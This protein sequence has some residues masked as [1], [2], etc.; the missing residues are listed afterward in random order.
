MYTPVQKHRVMFLVI[1]LMVAISA[2]GRIRPNPID[3]DAIL[4]SYTKL[5]YGKVSGN[6]IRDW[7]KEESA[8]ILIAIGTGCLNTL[9]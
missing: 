5:A 7:S 8:Y 1:I 2:F 3:V 9:T 6:H 4:D